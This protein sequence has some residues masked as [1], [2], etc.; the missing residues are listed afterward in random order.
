[1]INPL[2][3]WKAGLATTSIPSPSNL[4]SADNAVPNPSPESETKPA[5]QSVGTSQG[6]HVNE[7][8]A[9][10]GAQDERL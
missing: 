6:P 7:Q 9:K 3:L 8:G 10:E 2:L 4:N 1:M 5:A